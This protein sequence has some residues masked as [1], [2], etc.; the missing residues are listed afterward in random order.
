MRLMYLITVLLAL[1]NLSCSVS[2]PKMHWS[3]ISSSEDIEVVGYNIYYGSDKENLVDFQFVE[4][5][6]TTSYDLKD[7]IKSDWVT[8][9]SVCA[10]SKAGKEG[11]KSMIISYPQ[12]GGGGSLANQPKN[13]S[14]EEKERY[15]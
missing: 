12:G 9:F 15:E 7:L 6:F 5:E 10:V 13:S 4:G 3:R 11:P 1:T 14:K 2:G 8:Y